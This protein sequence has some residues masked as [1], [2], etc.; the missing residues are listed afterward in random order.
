VNEKSEGVAKNM[1][2]LTEQ[3]TDNC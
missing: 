2:S 3:T 1:T